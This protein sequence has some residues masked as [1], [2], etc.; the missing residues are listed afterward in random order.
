MRNLLTYTSDKFRARKCIFCT[1]FLCQICMGL[2]EIYSYAL[3]TKRSVKMAGYWPSFFFF[4][5][6]RNGDEV[7]V[8]KKSRKRTR[9]ISRIHCIAK[10]FALIRIKNDLF[11]SRVESESQLFLWHNKPKRVV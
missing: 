10:D 8:Q 7:S 3:L 2:L 1:V 9:L 6:F 4:C 5:V 11:I